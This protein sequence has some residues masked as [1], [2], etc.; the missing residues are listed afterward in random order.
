MGQ[1]FSLCCFWHVNYELLTSSGFSHPRCVKDQ[2]VSFLNITEGQSG[3]NGQN[4]TVRYSFDMFR[5]TADPH[6]LYLHCTVQLCE[7]DDHKSCIPV[8]SCCYYWGWF[9][10][11]DKMK[12][13]IFT[14]SSSLTFLSSIILFQN[15]NSISKREAVRADPDQGLLTYGPIRIEVPDRSQSSKLPFLY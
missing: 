6:D 3:R 14:V 12:C 2:T 8:S 13:I 9:R 10:S 5:F 1:N 7:L 4:S 15:C 11:V